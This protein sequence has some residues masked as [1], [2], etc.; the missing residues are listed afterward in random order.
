MD[1]TPLHALYLA[2]GGAI[3]AIC[4]GSFAGFHVYLVTFVGPSEVEIE[5]MLTLR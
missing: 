1:F 4:M 3:F 2:L 5:Q